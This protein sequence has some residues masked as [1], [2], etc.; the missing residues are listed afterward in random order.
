MTWKTA[1][2]G[3]KRSA[4]RSKLSTLIDVD[5]RCRVD[6]RL[7]K[8]GSFTTSRVDTRGAIKGRLGSLCSS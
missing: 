8:V 7:A 3:R 1:E 6:D 2:M 4:A 5:C